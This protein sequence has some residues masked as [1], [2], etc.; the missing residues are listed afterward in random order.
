MILMEIFQKN[1]Y[2]IKKCL[3]GYFMVIMGTSFWKENEY[4][5]THHQESMIK[6]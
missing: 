3:N 5:I 6:K 1:M 4:G 2:F